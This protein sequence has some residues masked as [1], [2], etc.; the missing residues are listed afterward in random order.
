MKIELNNHK[1]K[2]SE[3]K[4]TRKVISVNIELKHQI[5]LKRMGLNLSSLIRDVIDQLI[6]ENKK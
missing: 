6:V 4:T 2:K 1:K 5:F 3:I